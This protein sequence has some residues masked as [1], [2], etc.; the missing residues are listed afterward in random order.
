MRNF[1]RKYKRPRVAWN[2][3]QIA[4][5]HA[6]LQRYG[7]RRRR[8]LLRTQTLLR[9]W[10]GRARALIAKR[11]AEQERILIAKLQKLGLGCASLDD[12]LALELANILDRRLQSLIHTKGMAATLHHARQ[13]IVHGHIA[14][15]G[16]RTVFPSYL[17]PVEEEPTIVW[18]GKEPAKP[19]TK[20]AVES[21]VPDLA[22]ETPAD[23]APAPKAPAAD[24][25]SAGANVGTAADAVEEV[26]A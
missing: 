24:A 19:Q 21:A 7:L 20:A 2:T 16:R 1:K 26:A 3:Q 13:L 12:V 17:V 23:T 25:A 18:Y 15:A 8:E 9:D 5:T 14:V 6:L 11:N 22:R 10:R 4:D